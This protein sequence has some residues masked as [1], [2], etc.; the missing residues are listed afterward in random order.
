MKY[1]IIN[2]KQIKTMKNE[3]KQIVTVVE[4]ETKEQIVD[5]LSGLISNVE[6]SATL[7]AFKGTIALGKK[8]NKFY[9]IETTQLVGSS[10]FPD[11]T[12]C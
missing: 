4:C 8:G 12:D 10:P 3:K 9:A 5:T 2:Q 7:V 6:E 11:N 1:F